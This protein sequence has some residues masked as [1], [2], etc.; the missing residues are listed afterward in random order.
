MY[1]NRQLFSCGCAEMINAHAWLSH[2]I[3]QKCYLFHAQQ[4]PPFDEHRQGAAAGGASYIKACM[5]VH[6]GAQAGAGRQAALLDGGRAAK[7][8]PLGTEKPCSL[9]V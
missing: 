4:S 5:P 3:R 7:A 6:A 2:F 1:S 9:L 8:V